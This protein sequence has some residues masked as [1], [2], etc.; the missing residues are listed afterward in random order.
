MGLT[1][2]TEVFKRLDLPLGAYQMARFF[3][4]MEENDQF[5]E[6]TVMV[7]FSAAIRQ[8][9]EIEKCLILLDK[10]SIHHLWLVLNAINSDMPGNVL[11]QRLGNVSYL[12]IELE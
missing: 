1:M 11:R 10:R 7:E 12:N 2:P 6:P 8:P 3:Q 5:E 9:F 4:P